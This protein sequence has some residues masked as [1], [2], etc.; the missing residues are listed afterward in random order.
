MLNVNS[1]KALMSRVG[2]GS[3]LDMS[4]RHVFYESFMSFL[5]SVKCIR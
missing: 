1:N 3:W 2:D 5:H 4:V